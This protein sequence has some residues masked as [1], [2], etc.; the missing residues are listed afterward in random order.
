MEW[1][2]TRCTPRSDNGGHSVM[3]RAAGPG[4]YEGVPPAGGAF[5]ER[6]AD[7]DL[8]PPAER[9]QGLGERLRRTI[10]LAAN[11]T[12]V[13]FAYEGLRAANFYAK[14]ETQ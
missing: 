1:L 14:P 4:D 9:C 3:S 11:L 13:V 10:Q 7:A 8:R 2:A 12:I 6:R 5:G